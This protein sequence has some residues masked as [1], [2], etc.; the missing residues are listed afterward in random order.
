MYHS[1]VAKFD[2]EAQRVSLFDL[3]FQVL[4]VHPFWK[5]S[6]D[7]ELQLL[8]LLVD[9]I[10]PKRVQWTICL[11]KLLKKKENKWCEESPLPFKNPKTEHA[12]FVNSRVGLHKTPDKT[13]IPTKGQWPLNIHNVLFEFCF[14][15]INK[16]EHAVQSFAA[17]WE[18][19]QETLSK[20]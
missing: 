19:L 3:P 11:L 16:T 7:A 1:T 6:L 8:F 13:N 2:H 12:P 18:D 15:M 10:K 4:V 9:A 5:G 17:S 14:S 20:C